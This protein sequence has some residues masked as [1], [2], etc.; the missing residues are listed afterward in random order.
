MGSDV[1]GDLGLLDIF[2]QKLI[3]CARREALAELGDEEGPFVDFGEV[4]IFLNGF[5][6]IGADGNYAFFGALSHHTQ[7]GRGGVD[8]FGVEAGEF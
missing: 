1:E 7:G 6:G 2:L 4:A 3:H 8:L 5:G